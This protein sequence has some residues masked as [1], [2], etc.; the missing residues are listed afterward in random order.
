VLALILLALGYQAWEEGV[1]AIA[2]PEFQRRVAEATA[3][4]LLATI[5]ISALMTVLEFFNR[6]KGQH[7]PGS[8]Q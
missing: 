7:Q 5:P 4:G 1:R 2:N 6:R 8:I 3:A